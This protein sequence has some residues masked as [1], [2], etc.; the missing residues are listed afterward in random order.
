MV[1]NAYGVVHEVHQEALKLVKVN[2]TV[3]TPKKKKEAK[4]Q[5]ACYRCSEQ[6]LLKIF[7]EF[8][9]ESAVQWKG[10]LEKKG[11]CL[12]C[13]APNHDMRSCMHVQP[14]PFELCTE[15]QSSDLSA[16]GI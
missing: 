4:K 13:S 6:H 5:E 12:S 14:Y 8:L 3:A 15:K 10:F 2:H 7:L 1:S 11:P 9:K 16:Q